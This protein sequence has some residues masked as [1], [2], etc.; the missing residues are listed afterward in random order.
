MRTLSTYCRAPGS[1]LQTG[2]LAF[3]S[4]S[5][6]GSAPIRVYGKP[7]SVCIYTIRKAG[8]KLFRIETT[9]LEFHGMSCANWRHTVELIR[10]T[11]ECGAAICLIR[12]MNSAKHFA[13]CKQA[14]LFQH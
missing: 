4:I 3:M 13:F 9:P 6:A 14:T 8:T 10:Y 11:R 2:A 1:S 12:K 5:G 7:I